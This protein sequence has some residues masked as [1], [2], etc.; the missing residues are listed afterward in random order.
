M[1]DFSLSDLVPL[2]RVPSLLPKRPDGK[3]LAPATIWRWV[4]H[5]AAGRR[6]QAVRVG[7]GWYTT[8]RWLGEFIKYTPPTPAPAAPAAVQV[9]AAAAEAAEA[10][11][12]SR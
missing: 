4:Q 8:E 5:G 2:T 1:S 10:Y 7:R 12:R 9:N 3:R 11:L 6:L